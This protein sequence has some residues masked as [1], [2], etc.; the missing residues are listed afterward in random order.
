MPARRQKLILLEWF[1]LVFYFFHGMAF[2]LSDYSET[3]SRC[4]AYASAELGLVILSISIVFYWTRIFRRNR[5][6]SSVLLIAYLSACLIVSFGLSLSAA[7]VSVHASQ[8]LIDMTRTTGVC[9]G[10][11]I[12]LFAYYCLNGT[13]VKYIIAFIGWISL[14]RIVA[15]L[16]LIEMLYAAMLYAALLVLWTYN[17]V[18]EH[19]ASI[20]VSLY[21]SDIFVIKYNGKI[22]N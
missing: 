3:A 19:R 4:V 20:N 1:G 15:E 9:L 8:A 14:G 18:I 11:G 16:Y 21:F 10:I 22:C 6:V 17:Y 2:I 7:I 12:G 13:A 5:Y